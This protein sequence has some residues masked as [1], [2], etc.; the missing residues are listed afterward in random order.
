MIMSTY[1]TSLSEALQAAASINMAATHPSC[2]ESDRA[3]EMSAFIFIFNELLMERFKESGQ[4]LIVD[5]FEYLMNSGSI[6]NPITLESMDFNLTVDEIDLIY[7]TLFLGAEVKGQ[8]LSVKELR[9]A[10]LEPIFNENTKIK[11]GYKS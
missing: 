9:N 7:D 2:D 4:L 1:H 6:K 3:G 10:L 8:W 11:E 5:Y